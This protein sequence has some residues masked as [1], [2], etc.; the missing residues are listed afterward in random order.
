V[1][2]Y[3][4][5][6][7]KCHIKKAEQI[8]CKK[9]KNQEAARNQGKDEIILKLIQEWKDKAN[10][11]RTWGRIKRPTVFLRLTRNRKIRREEASEI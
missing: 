5:T 10:L 8:F 9:P 2:P 3:Q 1:A 11:E 6:R 7:R 4:A